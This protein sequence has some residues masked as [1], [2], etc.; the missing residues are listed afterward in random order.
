MYQYPYLVH[1]VDEYL[2]ERFNVSSDEIKRFCSSI[3]DVGIR[4][5]V[6][7]ACD[8]P[9]YWGIK[10][11]IKFSD[12][13]ALDSIES[14]DCMFM[15]MALIFARISQDA[16]SE[17]ELKKHA[18]DLLDESTENMHLYW[19]FM[20]EALDKEDIIDENFKRLKKKGISFIRDE[21]L[22]QEKMIK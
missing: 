10:Y 1:W 15:V 20:Y 7:E 6:Y 19:L 3:Y 4:S 5:K 16:K 8:Y 12:K 18:L 11:K 21:Y 17:N 9:M 14:G 2:F 13:Y 22:C